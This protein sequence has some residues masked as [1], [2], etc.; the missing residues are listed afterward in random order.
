MASPSRQTS[1]GDCPDYSF[2]AVYPELD[3]Q[4]TDKGRNALGACSHRYTIEVQGTPDMTR[5]VVSEC[6][7]R[8]ERVG[9]CCCPVEW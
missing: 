6:Q 3:V 5:S 9:S 2:V 4:I 7:R 8:L 1:V